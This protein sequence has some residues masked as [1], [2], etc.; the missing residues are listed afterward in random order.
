MAV[1]IPF[2]ELGDKIGSRI[3]IEASTLGEL[4]ADAR[5]RFG[6]P[7]VDAMKISSFVINGRACTALKGRATPLRPEDVV[8]MVRPTAGG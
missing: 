8:W 3:E 1:L 6:A 4:V 7:F 2:F 5:L